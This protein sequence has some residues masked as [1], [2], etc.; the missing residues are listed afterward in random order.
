MGKHENARYL[1]VE[2]AEKSYLQQEINIFYGCIPNNLL[3]KC[4]RHG[5]EPDNLPDPQPCGLLNSFYDHPGGCAMRILSQSPLTLVCTAISTAVMCIL[6]LTTWPSPQAGYNIRFLD[7][8]PP[9]SVLLPG[10]A[11]RTS[12]MQPSRLSG[13][14]RRTYIFYLPSNIYTS[15]ISFCVLQTT[16]PFLLVI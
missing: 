15:A 6:W 5:R 12:P 7:S 14:F 13:G 4:L 1:K 10:L 3:A 2:E 11:R 16:L 9:S 8:L